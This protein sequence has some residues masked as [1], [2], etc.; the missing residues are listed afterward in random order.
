MVL[1]LPAASQALEGRVS[2]VDTTFRAETPAQDTESTILWDDWRRK[3]Q[4]EIHRRIVKRTKEVGLQ[5]SGKVII[6]YTIYRSGRVVAEVMKDSSTNLG[7]VAPNCIESL[8]G[9]DLIR[10]PEASRRSKVVTIANFKVGGEETD[11]YFQ[12]DR[13]YV[14]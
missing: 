12:G 11:K 10:F 6:R 4:D 1:G 3:V 2:K 7:L 8:E 14:R 5:I 13:E 9:D